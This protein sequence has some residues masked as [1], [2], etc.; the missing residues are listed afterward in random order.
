MNIKP[1]KEHKVPFI[2]ENNANALT[3]NH[4]LLWPNPQK[5]WTGLELSNNVAFK[6]RKKNRYSV[7]IS[8]EK[9]DDMLIRHVLIKSGNE[10]LMIVQN[11]ENVKK[12]VLKF[13]FDLLLLDVMLVF[14]Y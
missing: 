14:I 13:S 9:I 2:P 7:S 11:M 6:K 8:S 3:G 12:C 4:V 5:V 1:T 10:V